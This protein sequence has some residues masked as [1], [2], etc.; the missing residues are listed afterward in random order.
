MAAVLGQA[1]AGTGRHEKRVRHGTGKGSRTVCNLFAGQV[2]MIRPCSSQKSHHS[3]GVQSMLQDSYGLAK[4]QHDLRGFSDF[5]RSLDAAVETIA[6]RPG[7]RASL[8]AAVSAIE[9]AIDEQARR[10]PRHPATDAIARDL[11]ETR[12]AALRQRFFRLPR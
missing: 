9:H 7:D 8:K 6:L 4:I 2:L 10:R 3:L 1:A 12:R 5:V 11:K